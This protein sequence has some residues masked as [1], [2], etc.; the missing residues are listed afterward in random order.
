MVAQTRSPGME[1]RGQGNRRNCYHLAYVSF[2]IGGCSPACVDGRPYG[3]I[4]Y[5]FKISR[6]TTVTVCFVFS[7]GRSPQVTGAQ[8]SSDISPT[9]SNVALYG[10]STMD[11]CPLKFARY[12]L[13]VTFLCGTGRIVSDALGS[14]MLAQDNCPLS[15]QPAM[16]LF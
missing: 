7:W 9:I 4:I 12:S 13:A 10:I 2:K 6:K 11:T 5:F 8:M 14:F 15:G 16:S 3:Q 1:E